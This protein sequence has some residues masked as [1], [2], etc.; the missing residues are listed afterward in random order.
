MNNTFW[1]GKRV[2]LTGHTGFKGSW[3]SLWLQSVG[4][5]L[6]GYALQPPTEPSLFELARVAEGM[7]SVIGDVCDRGHLQKVIAECKPEI[8]IHMAAQSVVR[9]SYTDP[10]STY[11][12]NVMGTV[13]LLEAIRQV[14]GV[15]VVVNVTT[16][17]CYENKEWVWGYRENDPLGGYDPYSSSKACSELVT[18]SYRDSFF[19]PSEYANHGVAI[20]SAR[21]GNVIGGG[22][23]TPD[24]LV[25][26]I[27]KSLLSKQPILIRNPYATRPWQHVLDALNGYLT[28]AE[29]LY[30]NG[31]AFADAWNFGPYE[32]SIKPV[33]WLVDQLLF[34]W[35]E[36]VH[37]EQDK[38]YQPHEANSLSLDCSK[39]RLKLGWEPK[40]SLVEALEQIIVWTKSYQSGA[41]MQE[42]TKAAIHRFMAIS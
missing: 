35:G 20:A 1:N 5:D 28:L 22:D 38:G 36:N 8:V 11:S 9:S 25:A 13:N 15:R 4:V 27:T 33:G 7:N 26:D 19:H 30:N 41:D 17:K 40:L 6:W 14:G 10:V 34:L 31:S 39:A 16:D 37:W 2:L 24:G 42:I 32:S 21:A 18:S 23:W 29:K 3:L 12:T